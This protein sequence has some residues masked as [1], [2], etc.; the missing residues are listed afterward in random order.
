M[1]ALSSR[2]HRIYLSY[3]LFV[4]F[5]FGFVAVQSLLGESLAAVFYA[6]T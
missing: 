3:K 6:L 1:A 5:I 4:G 2:V